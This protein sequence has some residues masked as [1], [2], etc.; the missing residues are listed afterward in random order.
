MHIHLLL[1]YKNDSCAGKCDRRGK[2]QQSSLLILLWTIPLFLLKVKLNRQG[3]R[4]R[5]SIYEE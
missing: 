2:S 1:L 4:L 5:M 3:E